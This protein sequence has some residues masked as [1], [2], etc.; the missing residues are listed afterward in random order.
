PDALRAKFERATGADLGAVRVHTGGASAD[1]AQQLAARAYTVGNDIHFGANQY[2]PDSRDGELLI[3]HEVAHAIQTGGAAAAPPRRRSIVPEP[4][5][6]CELDADRMAAAMVAGGTA[7]AAT[8]IASGTL[9]RA[10]LRWADAATA[11]RIAALID[12]ADPAAA[13]Q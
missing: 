12:R 7:T 2:D 11:E 8:G 10:I 4:A 1:S 3:A 13:H 6:A 5:D 9:A